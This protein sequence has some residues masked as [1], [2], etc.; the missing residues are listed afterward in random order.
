VY[1]CVYAHF[2]LLAGSKTQ[3]LLTDSESSG[4]PESIHSVRVMVCSFS[5]CVPVCVFCC[6]REAELE[7]LLIDLE[8]SSSQEA[9]YG[10]RVIVFAY[11]VRVCVCAF[12]LVLAGSR[13]RESLD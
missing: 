10:A 8:S 11:S 7:S 4:N 1:V 13:A 6:W 5:V 12:F 3:S 9:V 2:W